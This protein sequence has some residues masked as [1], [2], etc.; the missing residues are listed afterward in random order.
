[1]IYT[2]LST[3]IFLVVF[4]DQPQQKYDSYSP[5][6]IVY[7]GIDL[8]TKNHR[9][10]I[11]RAMLFDH[12]PPEV[13]NEL[14][15]GNLI[16]AEGQIV[17]I[18]NEAALHLNIR[19]DSKIA[20]KYYGSVETGNLLKITLLDGKEIKLKCY[21]GS[22][23][24]PTKDKSGFIYPL[25]YTLEKKQLKQLAK[26]ETD[27]IGIQWSSGYE[28]YLIYEIDFFINQIECLQHAQNSN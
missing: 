16:H 28:D 6:D 17:Q 2:I 25:G 27:K 13:K 9:I 18:N 4:A 23:G 1:M 8:E 5:C 10:E 21:A 20:Q 11:G 3:I 12:T 7:N 22:S 15:E 14:Q 26:L 24:V 19:I